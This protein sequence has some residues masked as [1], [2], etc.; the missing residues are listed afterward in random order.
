MRD[1][2][3][4]RTVAAAGDRPQRTDDL[5]TDSSAP[6][7]ADRQ[8]RESS[9]RSQAA[10]HCR[11]DIAAARRK[12]EMPSSML[13]LPVRPTV[14]SILLPTTWKLQDEVAVAGTAAQQGCCGMD[15]QNGGHQSGE[16]EA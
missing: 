14:S 9:R 13:V 5:R 3:V 4:D 11:D 2:G 15:N 16:A 1:G 12:P 7:E 6:P 8:D 10:V